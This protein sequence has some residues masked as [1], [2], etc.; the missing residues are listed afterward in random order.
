MC[1]LPGQLLSLAVDADHVQEVLANRAKWHLCYQLPDFRL[2]RS[3]MLCYYT[4]SGIRTRQVL[5]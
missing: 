4:D 2:F 5:P 1:Q 3:S